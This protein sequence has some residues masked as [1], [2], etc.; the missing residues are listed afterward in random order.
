MV[1]LLIHSLLRTLTNRGKVN[2]YYYVIYHQYT[3]SNISYYLTEANLINPMEEILLIT[4]T[5][6]AEASD[7]NTAR[8]LIFY[9]SSK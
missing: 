2:T 9:Q 1:N 5:E 3:A 4:A 8:N 6:A 7:G